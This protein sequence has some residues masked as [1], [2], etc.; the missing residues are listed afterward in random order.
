MKR[1]SFGQV[2]LA[3][4]LGSTPA[5]SQAGA[6]RTGAPHVVEIHVD[7]KPAYVA[8]TRTV[9]TEILLRISVVPVVLAGDAAGPSYPTPGEPF[10]R[11]YFDFR[12]PAP[13]LVIVDG[14]TQR[15][16]ERRTLPEGA[17]LETSVEAASHVLY[18]V[19]DSL[20]EEAPIEKSARTSDSAAAP[21]A[22]DPTPKREM[23]PQS[24]STFR[25]AKTKVEPE[26][27]AD[28]EAALDEAP[29]PILERD[30]A[31]S[32]GS[33][34]RHSSGFGLEAGVA[35][36]TLYLGASRLQPGGGL[37][38][39]LR[40][41]TGSPRFSVVGMVSAHAPVELGVDAASVTL[42]P[43][44]VALVPSFQSELA[45]H[46][47]ALVGASA[48][49]TWFSLNTGDRHGAR[50]ASSAGGA[51]VALGAV[52]GVRV[53]TSARLALT[54]SGTLDLDLMPR[55][56]LADVD[57]ERRVLAELPR[58]RPMVSLSATYSLLGAN[59]V[60]HVAEVD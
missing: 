41:D 35:F 3:A 48:S 27:D 22:A 24:P 56:F 42:L 4:V 7:G 32:N 50:A 26:I 25:K 40:N 59:G 30:A 18:M 53:R 37:A 19:V 49:L 44:T 21:V 36:R 38:L 8:Q 13:R 12:T 1:F 14:A 31:K 23:G 46:V 34:R 9:A 16:L 43:W 57:G 17:S 28:G 58:L 33:T 5:W 52:I 29:G 60:S 6:A 54:L 2:V 39:D 11:A 55:T 45:S 10:V 20:L 15:E 47:D 51:D